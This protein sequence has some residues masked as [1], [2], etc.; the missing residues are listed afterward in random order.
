M[1]WGGPAPDTLEVLPLPAERLLAAPLDALRVLRRLVHAL[2][3]VRL[4]VLTAQSEVIRASWCAG[5]ASHH[6]PR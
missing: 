3:H 2:L 4:R 6:N 5:S 1:L